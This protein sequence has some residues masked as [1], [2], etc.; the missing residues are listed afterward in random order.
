MRHFVSMRDRARSARVAPPLS[1]PTAV[2][3]H[4]GLAGPL[5]ILVGRG[6]RRIDRHYLPEDDRSGLRLLAV[7]QQQSDVIADVQIAG[8][9][10]KRCLQ[11]VDRIQR[12]AHFAIEISKLEPVAK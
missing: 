5:Q 3:G 1:D 12:P 6:K 11:R 9:Q 10:H 2:R 8:C 4:G 7:Q